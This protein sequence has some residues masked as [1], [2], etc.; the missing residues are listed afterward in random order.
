[1]EKDVTSG[2]KKFPILTLL[3]RIA[4][5]DNLF[6]KNTQGDGLCSLRVIMQAQDK[7]YK[8]HKDYSHRSSRFNEFINSLEVKRGDDG[9]KYEPCNMDIENIKIWMIAAQPRESLPTENWFDMIN[10]YQL[11]NLPRMSVFAVLDSILAVDVLQK[12]FVLVFSNVYP[13]PK[14][15]ESAPPYYVKATHNDLQK[16]C[17]GETIHLHNKHA[18][19][20]PK[21]QAQ[22]NIFDDCFYQEYD[23]LVERVNEFIADETQYCPAGF[24]YEYKDE[25]TSSTLTYTNELYKLK[26][27]DWIN[28]NIISSWIA[29]IQLEQANDAIC[30]YS[31]AEH[32]IDTF[33][34]AQFDRYAERWVGNSYDL[35]KLEYFVC[36]FNLSKS[37]WVFAIISLSDFVCRV[38]DSMPSDNNDEIMNKLTI[39]FNLSVKAIKIKCPSKYSEEEFTRRMETHTIV[40][41]NYPKQQNTVDCGLFVLYAI[42]EFFKTKSTEFNFSQKEVTQYREKLIQYFTNLFKAEVTE[43]ADRNDSGNEA[44]AK[45]EKR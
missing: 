40:H 42:E 3:K 31:N 8:P 29:R 36:P 23:K 1:M 38:Y 30:C 25:Y 4:K 21:T 27:R 26:S 37:H 10:Y 41:A 35:T 32:I 16:I 5:Q 7:V 39:I 45:D 24:N 11:E 12:Y 9:E 33:G 14:Q 18:F 44:D 2:L 20:I 15:H 43:D 22:Q 13:I 28:D 17:Y 19:I 34:P 6:K